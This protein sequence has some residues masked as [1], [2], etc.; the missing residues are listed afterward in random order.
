[1]KWLKLFEDFKINN[2][3]GDLIT[4]EDIINC[5]KTGGVIYTG[6]I[7]DLPD[8]NPEIPIKPIS[9]DEDGLITIEYDNNEYTVELKHVEKVE[10]K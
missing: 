6:V 3:E 8:N 2:I 4:Q 1:M 10:Y 5:I 7:K 9:I